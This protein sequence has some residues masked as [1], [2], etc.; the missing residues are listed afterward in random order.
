MLSWFSNGL[1]A[2]ASRIDVWRNKYANGSTRTETPGKRNWFSCNGSQDSD[3]RD[4]GQHEIGPGAIRQGGREGAGGRVVAGTPVGDC[5]TG[6]EREVGVI[7]ALSAAK[8][9]LSIPDEGSGELVSNLK[10]QKLLYYAQGYSVAMNGIDSPLFGEKMFAWKH[11]PVVQ[12][13][14]NHFSRFKD[15]ALPKE[16]RPALSEDAVGYLD[17]IYRVFGRYSAWTLREMTHK[18]SPWLKNYKPDVLNIEIPL[19]DLRE[20][21]L[22]YVQK[23]KTA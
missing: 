16:K 19:T 8:Y 10:L 3:G 1:R 7:T 15:G 18:E 20:Y 5:E 6:S 2:S 9:F 23:Q 12:K 11:G 17:E 22:P 14:Y 21:F 13:V 4:A